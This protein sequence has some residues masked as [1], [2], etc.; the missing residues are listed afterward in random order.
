MGVI[1]AG[2]AVVLPTWSPRTHGAL[3]LADAAARTCL[4]NA[5]HRAEALDL[6]VN[7]GVYRERGLGE[8]ALAALIQEDVAANAGRVTP[9][10]HG[11]FSFDLDNGACGVLTGLDVTRGFLTSQ[12]SRLAM[13]VASDSGPDPVHAR[14]LPRPEAGAALLVAS[15]DTVEGLSSVRLRTYPEY[16]EMFEGFWEWRDARRLRR[17]G[18]NHLVVL[19]RPGFADRAGE[20]AAELVTNFMREAEVRPQ[21][22]DLLVATPAP[23]FADR[24]ADLVGIDTARTLHIGEHLGRMH[25]AQPIAAIDEAQRTGR[26]SQARTILLVSAGS[27]ITVAAALYRH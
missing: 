17:H 11:T 14:A 21:D 7:V 12:A 8:P 2:T 5:G 24:L 13:V 25:S 23:D 3:R 4:A 26:W 20:C 6:L 19:E 9:G 15:D 27:G 22:I 1:V 10:R 16:A 18:S